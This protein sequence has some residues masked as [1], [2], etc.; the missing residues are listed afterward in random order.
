MRPWIR[1]PAVT[2]AVAI[3]NST[4]GKP[5]RFSALS[6]DI[7]GQGLICY[8]G[9][10]SGKKIVSAEMGNAKIE[11]TLTYVGRNYLKTTPNSKDGASKDGNKGKPCSIVSIAPDHCG[12]SAHYASP[13]PIDVRIMRINTDSRTRH[14][15]P[16]D[17]LIRGYQAVRRM[18]TLCSAR[19]D[20]DA[21]CGRTWKKGRRR[22]PAGREV[23]CFPLLRQNLPRKISFRSAKRGGGLEGR[24]GG[25]RECRKEDDIAGRVREERRE[26][27]VLG[28][29]SEQER[30]RERERETRDER[31]PSGQITA[32]TAAAAGSRSPECS[33]E[34]EGTCGKSRKLQQPAVVP[35][36]KGRAA[37]EENM[38]SGQLIGSSAGD[39][40]LP[41][42]RCFN[43]TPDISGSG[44]NDF[45]IFRGAGRTRV[46]GK[47]EEGERGKVPGRHTGCSVLSY[48][49][50]DFIIVGRGWLRRLTR[51]RV[52]RAEGAGGGRS[53]GGPVGETIGAERAGGLSK[54]KL[55]ARLHFMSKQQVPTGP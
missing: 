20:L 55:A 42:A 4:S 49:F 52:A 45:G 23:G 15:L 48:G 8:T 38:Q 5:F 26:E 27:R 47:P 44:V 40:G 13:G 29:E 37:L 1:Y 16:P 34:R 3:G 25:E 43:A 6:K 30:K 35:Y 39:T 50:M 17:K 41:G 53:D 14:A 18:P 10:L 7:P 36:R 31:Q 28:D 22:K 21:V 32:A 24:G 2:V 33:A 12:K 11:F 46:E 19:V 51:A 9:S 54:L